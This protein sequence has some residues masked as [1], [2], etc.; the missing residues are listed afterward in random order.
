MVLAYLGLALACDSLAA[1][2]LLPV[3]VLVLHVGVILR[4]ERYLEAKFED[5]YLDY[6]RR[7]RRWI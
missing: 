5:T 3:V 4:E 1:L 7:V 6:K 2:L